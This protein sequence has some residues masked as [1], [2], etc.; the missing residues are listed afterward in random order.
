MSMR[1]TQPQL[2]SGDRPVPWRRVLGLTAL[3]PLGFALLALARGAPEITERIYA[4][5]IYPVIRSALGGLAGLAPISLSEAALVAGVLTVAF[6]ILRALRLL[7]RRRR[8]LVNLAA[9]AL[10]QG[11]AG[12]GVGYA[13]FLLLWGLNH[14]RSPYAVSAGLELR[15]AGTDELAEVVEELV[16]RTNELRQGRL[17][18]ENGVLR[19]R[20]GQAGVLAS[21]KSAYASAARELPLLAGPSPVVRV[22]LASSLLTALGTSGIFSPFSGEAHVNGAQTDAQF[23]FSA[24]HE[25]AHERGFAR[26]DEANYIAYLI[27]AGAS[28]PDLSYAGNLCA[29]RYVL[30]ALS[31]VDGGRA[32][33][34]RARLAPA[35]LRDWKA[36]DAF[37]T[38][39][40]RTQEVLRGVSAEVNHS[41]L[42]SQ[43]QPAGTASYGRMVDLLLAA[44]RARR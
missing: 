11:L 10:G 19:L 13:L 36:I 31:G 30:G 2:R 37:W 23:A 25:V 44:R 17:E 12:L 42:K 4:R 9:H 18:D 32:T 7:R 35:V 28:D 20:D 27:A 33:A 26:E 24:C 14:A 22:P 21:V 1:G 40:S 41:Y 6:R 15:A 8:S 39:S 3:A 34:L 38:T 43:G 29:L 5:G 16:T